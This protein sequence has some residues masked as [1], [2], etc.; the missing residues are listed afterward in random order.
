[1]LC[2]LSYDHHEGMKCATPASKF[3]HAFRPVRRSGRIR[4]TLL[5]DL[6]TTDSVV[7]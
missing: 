4:V 7:S 5:S 6:V 1:M 2:Q 3:H